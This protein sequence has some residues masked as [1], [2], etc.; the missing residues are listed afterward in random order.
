MRA[1][2]RSLSHLRLFARPNMFASKYLLRGTTTTATT[3][4]WKWMHPKEEHGHVT[5]GDG[6]V[7]PVQRML[8]RASREEAF[9]AVCPHFLSTAEV[10][11]LM[12]TLD[13]STFHLPKDEITSGGYE[14]SDD[15]LARITTVK[16][17]G[18]NPNQN[19]ISKLVA[20]FLCRRPSWPSWLSF[21]Q[22]CGSYK[23]YCSKVSSK[24][25]SVTHRDAGEHSIVIYLEK[26]TAGEETIFP[27]FIENTS[28]GPLTIVPE[29]GTMLWFRNYNTKCGI[30]STRPLALLHQGEPVTAGRKI[31]LQIQ[32]NF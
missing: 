2:Y 27:H 6:R 17:Q 12:S 32:N 28:A 7:V 5:R 9:V 25:G 16:T 18:W 10:T 8:Q 13:L 20:P 11:E 31:I 29:V 15:E 4:P 14:I 23:F 30:F 1:I 22:L 21:R 3:T 26:P 24:V 19:H